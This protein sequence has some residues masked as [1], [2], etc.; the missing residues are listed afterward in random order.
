MDIYSPYFFIYDPPVQFI[1]WWAIK[2]KLRAIN[3]YNI[4]QNRNIVI[5]YNCYCYCC[6]IPLFHIP[7]LENRKKRNSSTNALAFV[8]KS[9]AAWVKNNQDLTAFFFVS[10]S[11]V[12]HAICFNELDS[13][14]KIILFRKELGWF[15][16][17]LINGFPW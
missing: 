3:I 10:G 9:T 11:R 2:E 1:H 13:K 5:V 8:W 16:K 17:K 6:I 14:Y 12:T 4:I 15:F 7:G